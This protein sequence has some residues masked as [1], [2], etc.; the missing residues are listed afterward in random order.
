[1]APATSSMLRATIKISMFSSRIEAS[2]ALG[3]RTVDAHDRW[4]PVVDIM[5]GQDSV[6]TRRYHS[7]HNDV[8][9]QVRLSGEH[10]PAFEYLTCRR[11]RPVQLNLWMK[12]P[13]Y[14]SA[15]KA[16]VEE[17]A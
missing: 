6:S 9:A 16:P 10:S 13:A 14:C 5:R 12:A 1:M 3:G 17:Q 2:N 7:R 8:V 11:L 15:G 4:N